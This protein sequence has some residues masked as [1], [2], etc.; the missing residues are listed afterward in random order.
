MHKKINFKKSQKFSIENSHKFCMCPDVWFSKIGSHIH[1]M[2]HNHRLVSQSLVHWD[3]VHPSQTGDKGIVHVHM[4]SDTQQFDHV[5]PVS[6][7]TGSLDGGKPYFR[8][9]P[10]RKAC[11]LRV[12]SSLWYV[13]SITWRL[14]WVSLTICVVVD[15]GK[16]WLQHDETKSIRT[17]LGEL[18]LMTYKWYCYQTFLLA[19]MA[20]RTQSKNLFLVWLVLYIFYDSG[21][22]HAL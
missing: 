3:I 4:G 9:S 10:R 18:S 17:R 20:N 1:I 22:Y 19:G 14:H 15:G 11:L 7:M 16:Q 21:G 6:P 5:V 13:E 2:T 12:C 8:S